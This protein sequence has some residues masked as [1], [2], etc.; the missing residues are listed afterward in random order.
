MD[1]VS[2][3]ILAGIVLSFTATVLGGSPKVMLM[4]E[5]LISGF[6]GL[7]F[8]LSVFN[9]RPMMYYLARATVMRTSADHAAVFDRVAIRD[10]GRCASWLVNMNA[11][12]GAGLVIETVIRVAL[13]ETLTPGQ[14]LLISPWVTYS[15]YGVLGGW[16]WWYR[17]RVIRRHGVKLDTL[18]TPA[19]GL[20]ETPSQD[21]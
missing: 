5:S 9:R 3:I 12:W 21:G 15:I 18:P 8:L 1:A 20:W 19:P 4:R 14:V 16:T 11:M 6:V 2:I 10:D 7:A 17:K 13:I